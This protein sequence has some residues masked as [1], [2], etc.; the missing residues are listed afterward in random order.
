MHPIASLSHQISNLLVEQQAELLV[1]EGVLWAK[2]KGRRDGPGGFLKLHLLCL[3]VRFCYSYFTPVTA[4][5]K[6]VT[7]GVHLNAVRIGR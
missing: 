5:Q 1:E 7:K 3:F 6:D 2:V 4:G